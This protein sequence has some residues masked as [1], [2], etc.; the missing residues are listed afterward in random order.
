[1]LGMAAGTWLGIRWSFRTE[2]AQP[3]R[4]ILVQCAAAALSV[5]LA[6]TLAG[7]PDALRGLA[8]IANLGFPMLAAV[9][10]TVGGLQFPIA[11]RLFFFSRGERSAGAMYG[12]DLLGSCVGALAVSLFVLPVFGLYRTAALLA[13]VNCAA[14]IGF[15]VVRRR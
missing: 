1:M 2:R 6:V 9:C 14:A 5:L 15:V 10:G 13:A 8:V 4:I 7:V 11:S 3:Y 12:F